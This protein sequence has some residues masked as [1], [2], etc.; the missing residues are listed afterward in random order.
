MASDLAMA[1]NR[2]QSFGDKSWQTFK[3]SLLNEHFPSFQMM[4]EVRLP[5]NFESLWYNQGPQDATKN[6]SPINQENST[7]QKPFPLVFVGG[8]VFLS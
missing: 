1:L 7:H 6:L 4:F 5:L 3:F 2:P 8:D